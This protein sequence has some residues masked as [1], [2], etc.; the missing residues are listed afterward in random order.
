[1][2]KFILLFPC[3]PLN[4][5]KKVDEDFDKEY[6][7]ARNAGFDIALF[8]HDALVSRGE[9]ILGS[10]PEKSVVILR[11]WMLSMAQYEKLHAH[12]LDMHITMMTTPSEYEL[13]HYW[14]KAYQAY[15]VLREMSPRCLWTEDKAFSPQHVKQFFNGAPVAVKDHV[16]SAKGVEG[17]MFIKNSRKKEEVWSVV[18]KMLKERG[19]LFERG[20]VFKEKIDIRKDNNDQ[21]IEMRL[22]F[23]RGRLLHASGNGCDYHRFMIPSEI[24]T[25]L[26]SELGEGFYVVDLALDASGAWR[27][28][29][30]GDGQVS[31]LTDR[32]NVGEFYRHLKWELARKEPGELDE[33]TLEDDYPVHWDYLYVVDGKVVCSNVKGTVRTLKEDLRSRGWPA[34]EVTTCDIFGRQ[35]KEEEA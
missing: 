1:M 19:P 14:P 22:F 20:I 29:E 26:G 18:D 28:L 21:N 13:K 31:G 10:V 35:K 12:L 5:I 6:E 27:V 33:R 34:Q 9:V 15:P 25:A 23:L 8:D 7:E 30:C 3:S 32:A 16:K 11:G 2:K 24:S 4:G 17:A